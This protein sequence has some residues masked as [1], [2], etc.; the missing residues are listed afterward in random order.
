MDNIGDQ[1]QAMLSDLISLIPNLIIALLLLLLAW[2]VATLAKNV[3]AKG[4]VKMGAARGLAKT[5]V[6]ENEE[7]GEETLKYISKIVYFLVFILFLPSVLDALNMEAVSQ[8]ITNMVQTFLAFLPNVFAAGIILFVGIF[9]ARLVKDLIFKF[10]ESLDIDRWFN[11]VTKS[12]QTAEGSTKLSSILANILFVVILIPIIT[13]ALETLNIDT[14]SQPIVSV[15]DSVLSMIPNVF[16]A[17]VL[18]LV[19][20]YLA[21][22][23]SDLLTSL[24]QRTGIDNIYS[25]FNVDTSKAPN[26]KV[27]TILGH[28]TNVII[29]LF[30]TVEALGV[31]QLEVLNN[32][33][34]AIL[35]YLPL[36]ISALVILGIGL[37]AADFLG[38]LVRKYTNSSFYSSVVKYI[39]II[40][41]VFMTFDQLQF[42]STIVNIAFLLIL[43]GISV[44]FA[45]AFGVGGRDFA[46]GKLNELDNKI[47]KENKT[48]SQ[49][50]S[51]EKQNNLKDL[52]GPDV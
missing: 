27:S 36:L 24:L 30:F 40:V 10:L 12:K 47:K 15:L 22:F 48:G 23:V 20:Y 43:G 25:Y 11:K 13:V 50:G 5:R 32:I 34:N 14:I 42:A 19:G 1:F 46:K 21:K 17:I 9:I 33:G 18:V 52:D 6:I 31:L 2:G 45:I 16:V 35:M 49:P 37:F 3:I 38:S 39:I 44:A 51:T 4:L 26:F 28:I 8:P 7:K 29:I 41:A